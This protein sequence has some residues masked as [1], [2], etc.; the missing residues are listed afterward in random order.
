MSKKMGRCPFLLKGHI[1]KD[2]KNLAR[3]ANRIQEAL[4]KLKHGRYLEL[5]RQ[6]TSL[7]G[8]LQQLTA[9]SRKMGTSLAKG[10]L[11]AAERCCKSVSRLLGDIQYSIPRIRPLAERPQK[12]TSTLSALVAELDALEDEFGGIEFDAS[13]NT[14]SVVTEPI[15]LEDIYLGPFKIQLELKK[16]SELYQSSP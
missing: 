13:E 11:S 5:I 8:Q 10:W 12:E 16:L 15:I 4:M 2:R 6:L 7:A 9:E 1:M 3:M 14:I